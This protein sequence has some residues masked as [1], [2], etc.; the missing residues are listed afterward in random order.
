MSANLILSQRVE[1]PKLMSLKVQP[2]DIKD[3]AY[4]E[5]D[6]YRKYLEIVVILNDGG[7][8]RLGLPEK[9]W[10]KVIDKLVEYYEAGNI[11]PEGFGWI[12]EEPKDDEY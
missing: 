7:I 11:M 8:V 1:Q 3:I 6:G 5:D 12:G 10:P 9:E 4:R 2:C